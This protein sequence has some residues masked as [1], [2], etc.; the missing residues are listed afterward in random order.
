MIE[1]ALVRIDSPF[2]LVSYTTT[3]LIFIVVFNDGERREGNPGIASYGL[4][5]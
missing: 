1:D 4:K 5:I 3:E 2:R